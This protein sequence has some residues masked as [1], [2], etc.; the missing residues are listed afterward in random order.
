MRDSKTNIK[1][2]FQFEERIKSLFSL[3]GYIDDYETVSSAAKGPIN[4]ALIKYWGKEDE[5]RIIPLNNS[6][7]ITLDMNECYT[8]TE[9]KL[10]VPT[11]DGVKNL[12]LFSKNINTLYLN[13]LQERLSKRLE[14]LV[15]YFRDKCEDKLLSSSPLIIES[16]NKLPTAAG[17]ASSASSMSCIVKV[18]SKIFL[19]DS[20]NDYQLSALARIGSGSACRSIQGGIVEWHKYNEELKDSVAKQVVDENYWP[21]LRVLL[22]IVS[23]KR[24]DTSSTDGMKTSKETSELLR[25]RL[26]VILPSR[27]EEMKKGIFERN[28]E[29]IC[30]LTVK[31]SNNFHAICRDTYPTINYLN[32][33]SNF[34][35]KCVEKIN[36]CFGKT[37]CGYTFDAG[38][39]AFILVEEGNIKMLREIFDYVFNL[40]PF[41]ETDDENLNNLIKKLSSEREDLNAKIIRIVEFKMG[42]G[43]QSESLV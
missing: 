28:F 30:E 22:M 32:D 35:I 13:N 26:G 18:L 41:H 21:E 5:E 33:T 42:S 34:I 25:H 9:A 16:V 6:I 24:K 3:C 36:S 4:I 11:G 27:I 1:E 14:N 43:I 29:K 17:C 7:S 39:N 23:D 19:N 8:Y 2:E 20:L 31:D 12:G 37:I 38:P 40:E 10:I 15:N